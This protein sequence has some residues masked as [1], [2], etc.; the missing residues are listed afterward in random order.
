M[1]SDRK[2]PSAAF[3]ITVALVAVLLGYPLSFGPACWI[4]ATGIVP[5]PFVQF[6]ANAYFPLTRHALCADF[7]TADILKW[8]AKRGPSGSVFALWR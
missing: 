5:E 8:W 7:P 3:W 2:H 1:T 4:T 6:I